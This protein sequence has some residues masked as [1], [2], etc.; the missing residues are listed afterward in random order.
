[1]NDKSARQAAM[2]TQIKS[3]NGLQYEESIEE[4]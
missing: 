4:I 2:V 3:V 1:M